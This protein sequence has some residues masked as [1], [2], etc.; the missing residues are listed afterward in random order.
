MISPG[1]SNINGLPASLIRSTRKIHFFKI[2]KKLLL[3]SLR[4]AVLTKNHSFGITVTLFNYNISKNIAFDTQFSFWNQPEITVYNKLDELILI[5][6]NGLA[7]LNT[8]HFRLIDKYALSITA[9]GGYKTGGY[10]EGEML[11]KGLI[12]RGGF[13]FNLD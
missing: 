13:S 12:L 4:Y 9:T 7:L 6:K 11:N 1:I 10:L 3:I 5:N 2:N 8:I